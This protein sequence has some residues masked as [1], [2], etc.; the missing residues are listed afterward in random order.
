MI[1][2]EKPVTN[3]FEPWRDE[4]LNLIY[5]NKNSMNTKLIFECTSA[6]TVAACLA[7]GGR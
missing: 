6:W 2:M 7:C 5:E 4:N 1:K 3:G